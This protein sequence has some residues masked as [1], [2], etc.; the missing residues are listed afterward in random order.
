MING[1]KGPLLDAFNDPEMFEKI[2]KHQMMCNEL[3][4]L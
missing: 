2:I 3:Y 4:E 1:I